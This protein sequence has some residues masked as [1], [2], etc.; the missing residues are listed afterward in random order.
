MASPGRER[1]QHQSQGLF[2]RF[3][4]DAGKLR[5]LRGHPPAKFRARGSEKRGP[6]GAMRRSRRPT[7][8][9]QTPCSC[10]RPAAK[11][12]CPTTARR[13]W[14]TRAWWPS[15]RCR[16]GGPRPPRTIPAAAARD[17]TARA[18]AE[19]PPAAQPAAIAAAAA[20]AALIRLCSPGTDNGGN[21]SAMVGRHFAARADGNG[22]HG[23][24]RRPQSLSPD[25]RRPRGH[26]GIERVEHGEVGRR[27]AGENPL[28]GRHVVGETRVPI[29]VVR[30]AAGNHRHVRHS[31]RRREVPEL[32]AADLQHD[33]IVAADLR[34]LRP[35]G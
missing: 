11:P 30:R 15:N 1:G 19:S 20:Q 8:R 33:P 14:S 28:L 24:L 10:P 13:R 6:A 7:A 32:K 25:Q 26:L 4:G 18:H 29:Q 23:L 31:G 22:C 16:I 21:S 34:Q 35:T 2:H 17:E 9:N 5:P 3:H 27:L 12:A